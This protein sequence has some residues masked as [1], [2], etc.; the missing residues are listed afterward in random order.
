MSQTAATSG[1]HDLAE[2]LRQLGWTLNYLEAD[3]GPDRSSVDLRCYDGNRNWIWARTN[4]AGAG[5]LLCVRREI[6]RGLPKKPWENIGNGPLELRANDTITKLSRAQGARSLMR[7]LAHQLA[8]HVEYLEEDQIKTILVSVMN[9]KSSFRQPSAALAPEADGED[10]VISLLVPIHNRS[11]AFWLGRSAGHYG[12]SI[13]PPDVVR[14]KQEKIDYEEGWLLGKKEKNR[15]I[16]ADKRTVVEYRGEIIVPSFQGLEADWGIRGR[17]LED[18][19]RNAGRF[20]CLG[21]A[22]KEIDR[23]HMVAALDIQGNA[24]P[25]SQSLDGDYTEDLSAPGL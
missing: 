5:E 23:L 7:I 8:G 25:N 22:Q 4:L 14:L 2:N 12:F 17:G 15:V 6:A 9:G 13:N 24:Y 10:S 19:M 1:V 18:G 21:D 20:T 11:D 3:F 16:E